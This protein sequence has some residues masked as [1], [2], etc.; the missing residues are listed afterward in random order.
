MAQ[1]ITYKKK[2]VKTT[3]M[4]RLNSTQ[5]NNKWITEEIKEEI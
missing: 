5:Q 1:E 2:T 4:W 3:S